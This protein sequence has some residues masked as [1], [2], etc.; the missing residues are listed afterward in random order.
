VGSALLAHLTDTHDVES[1]RPGDLHAELSRHV[2]E[3][4]ACVHAREW[5]IPN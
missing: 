1:E 2:R 3:N 5:P 4:S